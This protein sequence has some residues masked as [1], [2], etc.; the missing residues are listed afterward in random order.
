MFKKKKI[1]VHIPEII[2]QDI[3]S[4]YNAI[5]STQISGQSKIVENFEKKSK[6]SEKKRS[7]YYETS[8]KL[9][10]QRVGYGGETRGGKVVTESF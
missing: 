3:S 5:K 6:N 7:Y 9:Y 8:L 10:G 4:V 1:P 2:D